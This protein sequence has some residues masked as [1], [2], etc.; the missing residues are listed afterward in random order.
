MW[1]I[2]CDGCGKQSPV[3]VVQGGHRKPKDWF[4]RKDEQDGSI[5]DVCSISCIKLAN[6][7]IGKDAPIAG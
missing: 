3:E 1:I 4:Q 6:E 7:K 2:Q 5:L